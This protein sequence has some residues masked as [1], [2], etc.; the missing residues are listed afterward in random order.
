VTK[1]L[2][3]LNATTTL[4]SGVATS[5]VRYTKTEP[6]LRRSA[7]W[8]L[9]C[10]TFGGRSFNAQQLFYGTARVQCHTRIIVIWAVYASKYP[11]WSHHQQKGHTRYLR[12][13]FF[14]SFWI[15]GNCIEVFSKQ[16]PSSDEIDLS[17]SSLLQHIAF[18]WFVRVYSWCLSAEEGKNIG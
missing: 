6:Y 17:I 15:L 4:C 13:N 11:D 8:M 1:K 14:C 12:S 9:R 10:T 16:K 18:V 5:R 2:N 3:I 7:T